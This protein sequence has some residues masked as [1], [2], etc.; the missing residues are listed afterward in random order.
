[1]F[2]PWVNVCYLKSLP[3]LRLYQLGHCI[4]L[5]VVFTSSP[6]SPHDCIESYLSSLYTLKQHC[7]GGAGLPNHMM[8]E[9]SCMGPKRKTFLGP[10]VFNLL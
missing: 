8:G 7:L 3:M 2:R 1:M 4:L 5:S 10:L 6:T 9:V